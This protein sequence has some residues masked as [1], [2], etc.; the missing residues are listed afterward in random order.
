MLLE[1]FGELWVVAEADALQEA[2]GD[3]E[4]GAVSVRGVEDGEVGADLLCEVGGGEAVAVEGGRVGSG[5]ALASGFPVEDGE[6]I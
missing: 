3:V 2:G 5:G 6:G 1:G 4:L